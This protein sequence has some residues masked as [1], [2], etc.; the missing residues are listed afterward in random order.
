MSRIWRT[1]SIVALTLMLAS[2]HIA[3]LQVIAWSG[4]LVTRTYE[5]D[6]KSAVASTFSGAHPCSMCKMVGTLTDAEHVDSATKSPPKKAEKPM[7]KS[8]ALPDH[9]WFVAAERVASIDRKPQILGDLVAQWVLTP[10]PPP[11]RPA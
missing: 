9:V 4:M 6:L 2:G 7:K 8:D 3:A 1:W 5:G 10:E 11:P